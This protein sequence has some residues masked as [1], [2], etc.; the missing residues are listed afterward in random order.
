[1]TLASHEKRACYARGTPAGVAAT[2]DRTMTRRL[3]D[4][5]RAYSAALRRYVT[6]PSRHQL[7]E[8]LLLGRQVVA[9][10]LETL[11]LARI[12]RR[13][14]GVVTTGRISRARTR[15]AEAFF[16]EAA[17]AVV[18]RQDAAVSGP[19]R[20]I[21]LK[22]MLV[23]RTAELA[24]ST[25]KLKRTIELR[26][27]AEEALQSSTLR[28]HG[29]MR[30]AERKYINLRQ[31]ARHALAA[32]EQQRNALSHEL[33]DDVAQT[34][35]GINVQLLLLR[36]RSGIAQ[37]GIIHDIALTQQLVQQSTKALHKATRRIRTP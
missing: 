20:F 11:D 2:G 14:L 29:L 35:L 37:Q 4:V 8:A 23:V 21:R 28:N 24:E 31:L 5:S 6:A 17:T 27:S 13:A 32:H 18:E 22:K 16:Q 30:K 19:Q 10:G 7:H 36:T 25:A 1:V 15:R 3:I 26:L 34:L 33:Q 12:H 9:L